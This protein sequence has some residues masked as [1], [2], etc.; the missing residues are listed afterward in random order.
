M[1][2]LNRVFQIRVLRGWILKGSRTSVV[3]SPESTLRRLLVPSVGLWR[4]LQSLKGC[5]SNSGAHSRLE[6]TFRV[7]V[8]LA[9]ER[10]CS[11][12]LPCLHS[13]ILLISGL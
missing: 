12:L 8:E 9:N 5:Q 4:R 7:F 2:R 6:Q 10:Q 1:G 11:T 13:H 3:A